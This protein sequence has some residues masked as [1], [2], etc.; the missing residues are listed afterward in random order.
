[1][2][3]LFNHTSYSD[4]SLLKALEYAKRTM[5]VQGDV[6]VQVRYYV[7]GPSGLM[8][9]SRPY[10]DKV[11]GN[12]KKFAHRKY[13][14]TIKSDFGLTREIDSAT[15]DG[16]IGHILVRVPRPRKGGMTLSQAKFVMETMLHELGHVWQYR[17]KEAAMAEAGVK[18]WDTFQGYGN[19]R[20]RRTNY[21]TRIIE[22]HV[23]E[24]LKKVDVSDA[25]VEALRI[26]LGGEK[27]KKKQTVKYNK[28]GQRMSDYRNVKM[29]RLRS[30]DE[31]VR[32][33]HCGEKSIVL[34][35]HINDKYKIY[36]HIAAVDDELVRHGYTVSESRYTQYGCVERI[37]GSEV[38][39]WGHIKMEG[40]D[41]LKSFSS[42]P[43]SRRW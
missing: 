13:S 21:S 3:E 28:Y 31:V 16:S 6:A 23:R 29:N 18:N 10:F 42:N 8:W 11:A 41:H 43:H 27:P 22:V 37:N 32:C 12:L 25:E 7:N 40:D 1:M 14:A 26:A 4:E 34:E 39:K 38:V 24:M 2:I 20:Y 9:G 33:P 30:G 17:N 5:K 19:S 35:Q 36:T 15:K